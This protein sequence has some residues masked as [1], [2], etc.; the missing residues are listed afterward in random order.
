MSK[1]IIIGAVVLALVLAAGY[2]IW[3]GAPVGPAGEV[4]TIKNVDMLNAAPGL[5]VTGNDAPYFEKANGYFAKP[6][7]AGQY[8]G[9]V[10]VHEWWG[11]ND[12]IKQLAKQLA[13]EGYMVLAVDLYNGQVAA[14]A[15]QARALVTGIDQVKANANMKAAAAFLRKAGAVK[16][17]SLGWCFGGGQSLQFA[18]SGE[19]LDATIIYYGQL[20]SDQ[21]KLKS[22]KWPVLGVFGDKDTSITPDSVKSFE[23][24]LN[25][26]G[27]QNEIYLYTG[28]GHAFANPSGQNYAPNETKDAW[29]K[30]LTFL[31]KNLK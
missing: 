20:T 14:D 5:K 18:L 27:V 2:M 7:A 8:P 19:K 21:A 10:M 1:K 26:V 17:A 6:E 13:A 16:M 31:Q 29:A 12:N 4:S 28:V 9:V 25:Q 30:T 3:S 15:T 24:A 22:L 23:T 11:L